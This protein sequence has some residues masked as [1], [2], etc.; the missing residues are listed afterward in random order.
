MVGES[1]R[2]FVDCVVEDAEPLVGVEDGLI[3]TEVLVA[4]E[5]SAETGKPVEL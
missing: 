5:R 4:A 1:I 3:N 2:H